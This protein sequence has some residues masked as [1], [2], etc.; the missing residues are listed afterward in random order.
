MRSSNLLLKICT[1]VFDMSPTEEQDTQDDPFAC[2]DSDED[3]HEEDHLEKSGVKEITPASK[4]DQSRDPTCGVLAFHYGTESALLTYAQNEI[5]DATL[6]TAEEAAKAVLGSIDR[7]C[8]ERHWMMHVGPE[9]GA[10][11]ETFL[12]QCIQTRTTKNQSEFTLVELGTYCGYASIYLAATMLQQSN[13]PFHIY[14]VEVNLHHVHVAQQLIRLAKLDNYISVLTVDL[15]RKDH[16]VELLKS[17]CGVSHTDFLLIDHD[18]DGYLPDLRV[19]EEA[20]MVVQGTHVAAD[21][22]VFAQID[23]YRQY[24]QELVVQGVV[25]TRLIES[26]LEYSSPEK[27]SS[28]IFR[29]GIELTVYLR[30]PC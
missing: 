18:K 1:T 27:A 23:S 29:D 20:G 3:D 15:Q 9:K 21:N 22:V 7:F 26:D 16:L 8:L 4:V 13:A 17:E 24:M 30:D 11:L 2:F 5:G 10:Q 6:A 25:E 12:L 19:L 14:T 28:E